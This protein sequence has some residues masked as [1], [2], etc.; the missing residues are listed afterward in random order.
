M[1]EA[2]RARPFPPQPE[3]KKMKKRFDPVRVFLFFGHDMGERPFI[4]EE[5]FQMTAEERVERL[6]ARMDAYRRARGKRK[7]ALL[8]SGCAGLALCLAVLLYGK[9]TH[10]CGTAGQYSGAIV[11][12]EN[13]GGY[14][15]TA[16]AAFMAGVVIT[17]ILKKRKERGAAPKAAEED[18]HHRLGFLE[19][20]ALS[21]AAGGRDSVPEEKESE[22]AK[23][24]G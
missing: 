16:V 9:M 24:G 13:A 6:H 23:D 2:E 17:V 15:I 21:G 5:E 19:D 11:L 3:N 1:K 18:P 10:C 12:F 8:G 4:R 22:K 20:H 14:V 7:N